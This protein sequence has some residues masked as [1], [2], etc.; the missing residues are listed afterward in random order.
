[1]PT[2]YENERPFEATCQKILKWG[3]PTITGTFLGVPIVRTIVNW[4]LHW[5]PYLGKL[6]NGFVVVGAPAQLLPH[7]TRHQR[8]SLQRFENLLLG[9]WDVPRPTLPSGV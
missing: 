5:V 2:S 7:P 9:A 3:F 4:G 6:P 1:M 8:R